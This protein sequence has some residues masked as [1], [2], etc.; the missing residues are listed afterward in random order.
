MLISCA[1]GFL[2]V[3]SNH[4]LLHTREVLLSACYLTEDGQTEAW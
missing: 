3:L 2:F 1:D 4:D